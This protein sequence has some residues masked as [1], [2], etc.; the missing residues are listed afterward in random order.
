LEIRNKKIYLNVSFILLCSMMIEITFAQYAVRFDDDN[1]YISYGEAV[2]LNVANITIEAWIK[3][4]DYR[5]GVILAKPGAYY[6]R[7]NDD[8]LPDA[9]IYNET[10][11]DWFTVTGTTE[12]DF[13]E[14]YHVAFTHDGSYLR[15][16]L[17]GALEAS[18]PYSGNIE[19]L[20]TNGLYAG[21]HFFMDDYT[22]YTDPEEDLLIYDHENYSNNDPN[23]ATQQIDL[24]NNCYHFTGDNTTDNEDEAIS[25]IRGFTGLDYIVQ[26]DMSWE[27]LHGH[28]Y[29]TKRFENVEDK[30][31]I[32]IDPNWPGIT[33]NKVVDDDWYEIEA[34]MLDPG[35]QIETDE[36]YTVKSKITTLESTN[37]VKAWFN[38]NLYVDNNDPDLYF[39]KLGIITHDH[40]TGF[41]YNVN[42]DNWVVYIPFKGIIDEIR[43]FDTAIAQ[44]TIID[45]MCQ[46]VTGSH[47]NWFDLQGYWRFD[48]HHDPTEDNSSNSNEGDIVNASFVSSKVPEGYACHS[49]SGNNDLIETVD[50]PVSIR[51]DSN[52]PGSGAIYNVMQINDYPNQTDGL[53]INYP[54][55]YWEILI[56]NHD[57]SFNADVDFHYDN[58]GP[59]SDESALSLFTRSSTGDSWTLVSNIT[60]NDEG[61]NT[62]GIGYITANNLT[63]FSQFIISSNSEDN[64]L[65]V[66]LTSFTARVEDNKVILNWRTESEIDNQGFEIERSIKVEQNSDHNWG[67]IGFVSGQGKYSSFT[68]Y[69]FIDADLGN[70]GKYFYRL[71][72]IDINGKYI[73]SSILE[74]NYLNPAEHL[75]SDYYLGQNYP[76]P[77]NPITTIQYR[78]PVDS[79]LRLTVY[80]LLGREVAELYNGISE[81]G[82]HSIKFNACDLENGIYYYR[83]QARSLD[84]KRN[85][86]TTRK[87]ILIK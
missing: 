21:S 3:L 2:V 77:F 53:Y 18:T 58:L 69:S 1:A 23:T 29:I 19:P 80:D 12:L 68:N 66:E 17:N 82:D 87:M 4:T 54:S 13:N 79:H 45:W 73:Y 78:L 32:E 6:L 65:P 35:D 26:V 11:E 64:S 14:F 28:G 5:T 50:V 20:L 15:I 49:G 39:N 46:L 37:N 61:I 22:D 27:Q 51:W 62:D 55:V 84:N 81:L 7:V 86:T 56:Y 67:M 72:Q 74:V 44:N 57:G 70:S 47:P 42:F 75:A 76:N 34:H 71:K 40:D 59:I 38:N 25:I 83:I 9:G 63:S 85:F 10:D 30:Y 41:T 43:I 52:L 60:I 36:W 48:D 33:F 16:Y 31:E 8:C 24:I